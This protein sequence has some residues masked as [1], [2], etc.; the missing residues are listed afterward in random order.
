MRQLAPGR[1]LRALS[2]ALA[3]RGIAARSGKPFEAKALS[4]I[5]AREA[6]AAVADSSIGHTVAA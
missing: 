5:L 6:S 4:R 1:S 3:E 2:A